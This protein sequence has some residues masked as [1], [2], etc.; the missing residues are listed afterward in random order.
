MAI[1]KYRVG[2]WCLRR[3]SKSLQNF[4]LQSMWFSAIWTRLK[5]TKLSENPHRR[6]ETEISSVV[7]S[8]SD[9]KDPNMSFFKDCN[10]SM[11]RDGRLKMWTKVGCTTIS[12]RFQELPRPCIILWLAS[13]PFHIMWKMK[14]W[15]PY[16]MSARVWQSF[17]TLP[18]PYRDCF[19]S[20]VASY[21]LSPESLNDCKCVYD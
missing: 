14:T 4:R 5:M 15:L 3:A 9:S 20:T 11:E 19:E 13:H 6:L 18:S 12:K 21:L 1:K 2:N 17:G 7:W 16:H 8:R 10:S